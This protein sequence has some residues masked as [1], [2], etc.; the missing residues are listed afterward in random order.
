M[1]VV[2]PTRGLLTLARFRDCRG[3]VPTVVGEVDNEENWLPLFGLNILD[4]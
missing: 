2:T 3:E 1:V 4:P